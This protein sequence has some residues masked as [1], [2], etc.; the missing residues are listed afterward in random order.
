[1]NSENVGPLRLWR[2]QEGDNAPYSRVVL[3]GLKVVA[4]TVWD[5]GEW[6][7]VAKKE[8]PF[9]VEASYRTAI[10]DITGMSMAES[11]DSATTER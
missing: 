9:I 6:A 3:R 7:Y 4:P 11:A 10:E 2:F 1:M 8:D 5:S